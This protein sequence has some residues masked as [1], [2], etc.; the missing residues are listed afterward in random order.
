MRVITSVAA[1]ALIAAAFLAAPDAQA[2]RRGATT[3]GVVVVNYQRIAAESAIGQDMSNKLRGVASQIQQERVALNPEGQAIEQE[4]QRLGAATRSMTPEQARNHATHGPALRA[5]ETRVQQFQQRTGA[6]QGDLEC[7][8][9]LTLREFDGQVRPIIRAEMER[10][11]ANIVLDSSNVLIGQPD[12][13]VTDAVIRALDGNQA[14]RVA[15]VSRRPL[16]Q[17]Q[18]QQPAQ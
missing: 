12:A 13:D 10:R 5:L 3:G 14:T 4:G 11:G 1:A 7:T 16:S 18:Q 6:L 8:Q 15:N 2:Q 9:A 17:C